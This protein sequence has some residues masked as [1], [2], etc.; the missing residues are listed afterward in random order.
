MPGTAL[1]TKATNGDT[2]T[3][4]LHSCCS[5][6]AEAGNVTADPVPEIVPGTVAD[7]ATSAGLSGG[8]AKEHTEYD[9]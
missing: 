7:P 1:A 5:D 2:E 6:D 9:R 4:D 3:S 8:G